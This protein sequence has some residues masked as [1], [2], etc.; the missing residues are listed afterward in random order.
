[1]RNGRRPTRAQKVFLA[2]YNL[3]PDN[4]LIISDTPKR[5]VIRHRISDKIRTLERSG[6]A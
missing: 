1:M 4:W 6:R 5:L 2:K 3:S